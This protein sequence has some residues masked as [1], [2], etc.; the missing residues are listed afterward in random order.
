MHLTK[1]RRNLGAARPFR[2]HF[3]PDEKEWLFQ[4][5]LR[6]ERQRQAQGLIIDYSAMR[7][8]DIMN[9]FNN[10]FAGKVLPGSSE[11]R[12]ART[13]VALRTER[14]R[15]DKIT[16]HTGIPS[17][18]RRASKA[19]RSQESEESDE[20]SDEDELEYG[21]V[22]TRRG[23]PPPGKPPRRDEDDDNIGGGI[24]GRAERRAVGVKG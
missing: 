3:H 7:W 18:N 8:G 13:K 10:R 9:R 24:G 17:T 11:P 14:A 22:S 23:D 15:I 19:N 4:E 21:P 20:G 16:D 2:T 6:F 5:H 12:P 1:Y